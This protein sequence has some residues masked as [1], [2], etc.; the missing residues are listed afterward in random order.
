MTH[1]APGIHPLAR[2]LARAALLCCVAL[3]VIGLLP[4]PTDVLTR[5]TG[6]PLWFDTVAAGLGLVAALLLGSARLHRHPTSVTIGVLAGAALLWTSTGLLIQV[7]GVPLAFFGMPMPYELLPM[8]VR[9]VAAIAFALLA[10]SMLSGRTFATPGPRGSWFGI[11]ALVLV[12]VYPA[13]KTAWA[14]GFDIGVIG[15]SV[16]QGFDA[17]WIP[18]IFALAGAVLILA[19]LFRGFGFLPRW[20]LLAGGWFGA[21]ALITIIPVLLVPAE[22][23]EPA[24]LAEWVFTLFYGSWALLGPAL[25]ATTWVYQLRTRPGD[26][27]VAA[28]PVAAR[29]P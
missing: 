15:E 26:G 22:S 1:P 27:I 7:F 17:G 25:A 28:D 24:A 19:L 2:S 8:A 14:L 23:S 9:T 11:A 5:T 18:A 6:V 10:A 3:A 13:V 21:G 20:L 4:A 12:L 16:A 29:L